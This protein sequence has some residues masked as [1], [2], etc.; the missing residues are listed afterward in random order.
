MFAQKTG[1][2][3]F[4]VGAVTFVLPCGFTQTAQALAL[5]SGSA[6][7]GSLMMTAFALGTL[8]VLLG[9]TAFGSAAAFKHRVLRLLTGAVLALFAFGQ[10]DGGLTV[11]GSPL[12]LGGLADRMFNATAQA[13]A[14]PADAKE[15]VVKMTVA[16]GAFSPNR[17]TLRRGIPVRWEVNGVDVYGCASSIV[18][19]KMRIWKALSKGLNVIEFTPTQD[20]VIPFSCSMGM[21]R[22]SFNVIN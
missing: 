22:G 3:P 8:P 18:V 2:A 13:V 9:L 5:A 19:P 12:T 20:G 11:L 21:I 15:Q 1:V 14:V 17:F 6:W 10:L 4:F 7:R 16:Y